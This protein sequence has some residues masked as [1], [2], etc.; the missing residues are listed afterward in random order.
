MFQLIFQIFK[1]RMWLSVLLVFIFAMTILN[2]SATIGLSG[3]MLR[4][5]W[6]TM[7]EYVYAETVYLP[8]VDRGDLH[9][10]ASF[11]AP[12]KSPISPYAQY[13]GYEDKG[14]F[15]YA[16][17]RFVV[18]DEHWKIPLLTGQYPKDDQEVV[19]TFKFADDNGLRVGDQIKWV[20]QKKTLDVRVVGLTRDL[21]FD[22]Y[23]IT[24]TRGF[25]GGL[26][27]EAVD[28]HTFSVNY[29]KAK[30][31]QVLL[32][33]Y[34]QVYGHAPYAEWWTSEVLNYSILGASVMPVTMALILWLLM[35][36]LL[37]LILYL[38]LLNIIKMAPYEV[39][40]SY[41]SCQI[42]LTVYV[43]YIVMCCF[44]AMGLVAMFSG[45]YYEGMKQLVSDS[46]SIITLTNIA[47]M[48]LMSFAI[49][50]MIIVGISSLVNWQV[51]A[52]H[53]RQV[54]F[55]ERKSANQ[56]KG[57]LYGVMGVFLANVVLL[58]M[59]VLATQGIGALNAFFV[60]PSLWGYVEGTSYANVKGFDEEG[61]SHRP[62]AIYF[63][64]PVYVKN[65]VVKGK[66][67]QI[68]L[69]LIEGRYAKWP[70]E[71]VVGSKLAA[72]GATEGANIIIMTEE[73]QKPYLV[74]GVAD[75]MHNKG[76]MIWSIGEGIQ[77]FLFWNTEGSPR[78]NFPAFVKDQND[79]MIKSSLMYVQIILWGTALICSVMTIYTYWRLRGELKQYV[80]LLKLAYLP[81]HKIVIACLLLATLIMILV[82]LVV[83]VV[84]LPILGWVFKVLIIRYGATSMTPFV[85]GNIE[86]WVLAMLWVVNGLMVDVFIYRP[87]I[88]PMSER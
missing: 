23:Y 18:W 72:M 39:M 61:F 86:G 2:T 17:I 43:N 70:N 47:G 67:S 50:I 10:F 49:M 38:T 24:P 29:S 55:L 64:E 81:K 4:D 80:R 37:V 44:L 13:Y 40:S 68:G 35:L 66:M 21:H 52:R 77:D 11:E 6:S 8:G 82:Y 84:V 15:T 27:P 33:H 71:V 87:F 57:I 79:A 65:L 62:A 22:S 32:N 16:E 20:G 88:S 9:I 51:V 34:D 53:K 45:V 36:L 19:V 69:K 76:L 63:D 25:V 56:S 7:S 85:Q 31:R 46:V 3:L 30:S 26:S 58:S 59:M 73:G 48:H 41:S 78:V 5:V 12:E 60:K 75:V 74:V 14:Q 54:S 28:G 42:Y 1:R 83:L